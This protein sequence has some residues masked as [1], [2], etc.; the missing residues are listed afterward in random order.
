MCFYV[1]E[2]NELI[3][4]ELGQMSGIIIIAVITDFLFS[5]KYLIF[6]GEIFTFF[7]ENISGNYLSLVTMQ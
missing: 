2:I 4:C 1:S 7:K 3:K 6:Y 5:A